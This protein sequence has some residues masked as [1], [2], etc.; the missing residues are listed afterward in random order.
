MRQTQLLSCLCAAGDSDS[1]CPCF[2]LQPSPAGLLIQHAGY[3][4][5]YRVP[6]LVCYPSAC[7]NCNPCMQGSQCSVRVLREVEA[8]TNSHH[9]STPSASLCYLTVGRIPHCRALSSA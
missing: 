4:G 5:C 7:C 2:K 9:S 3:A 8:A 1:N 6:S